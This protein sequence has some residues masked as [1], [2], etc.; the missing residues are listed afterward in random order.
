VV[1][2][3][4][5]E[6]IAGVALINM[7]SPSSP[8]GGPGGAGASLALAC[9]DMV[10]LAGRLAQQHAQELKELLRLPGDHANQA[11][12]KLQALAQALHHILSISTSAGEDGGSGGAMTIEGEGQDRS[13]NEVRS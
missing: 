11:R 7:A 5:N 12:T 8:E 1:T 2:T 10:D 6:H 9:L 4:S 13:R 3:G